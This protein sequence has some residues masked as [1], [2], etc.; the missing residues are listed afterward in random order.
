MIRDEEP[1]TWMG[2]LSR[3]DLWYPDPIA[4][5]NALADAARDFDW[6]RVLKLVR[7][8]PE[9]LN[10]TRPGGKALLA[11]LHQAAHGGAPLEV[12]EELV[13]LG[14]WRT[15]RTAA[16]ERPVDIAARLRHDHLI[17]ALTPVIR[18][19]VPL[20]A[21]A[22][23]QT[24][25]QEVINGRVTHLPSP[26]GLR[27]PELE[28][29]LEMK[30][31]RMWFPVPQMYGGFSY[32]LARVGSDPLLVSESWCRVVGGSGQRHEVTARGS[33]LVARGIDL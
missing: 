24:H 7:G 33:S 14:A 30:E 23:V 4:K 9:M 26:H 13:Q 6:A 2:S 18:R 28:P 20:D 1:V 12:V 21:L 19:N 3:P 32:W 29:L 15:L 16:R 10:A 17:E 25:F 27:L 5:F 8:D 22:A 11:P 31:S